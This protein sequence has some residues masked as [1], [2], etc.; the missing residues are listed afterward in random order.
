M[1]N[2][3]LQ[4]VLAEAKAKGSLLEISEEFLLHL[5]HSALSFDDNDL[6]VELQKRKRVRENVRWFTL[7]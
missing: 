2:N 6:E 5:V 4:S 3:N 1:A 7:T